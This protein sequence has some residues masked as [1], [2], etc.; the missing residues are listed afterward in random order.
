MLLL[1][2]AEEA[3]EVGQRAAKAA[4]FGLGEIQPGQEKTN[5]RRLQEEILD[6]EAVIGMIPE[7]DES[8]PEG[9]VAAAFAA[10]RAKVEK[11]LEY[12]RSLGQLAGDPAGRQPGSHADAVQAPAETRRKCEACG[13][14]Y[15]AS[16][17]TPASHA[18]EFAP[19][20]NF[21][22]LSRAVCAGSGKPCRLPDDPRPLRTW[23]HGGSTS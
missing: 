19:T 23:W 10:K 4:R 11:F 18:D 5:V 15:D 12:S 17:Y 3:A 9:E 22:Q 13:W 14:A 6:L 7:V 16:R 20:H 21:P 1:Q 2:I 8:W